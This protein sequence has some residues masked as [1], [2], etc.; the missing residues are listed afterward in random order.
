[1]CACAAFAP[2]RVAKA[3]DKQGSAHGGAVAGADSGFG[4]SGSVLFGVAVY[5]PT[6]AARP[7]NTGRALLRFAPHFDIDLIGRRLSIPIDLNFFSDRERR[8]LGKLA[9]SEFDFIAGL[10]S[11]WPV[12]DL[13][14]VEFGVRGETDRPVDRSGYTQTYGDARARLLYQLTP[15][16]PRLDAL[17]HGGGPGGVLTLG[18]FFWNPSYAARPDNTGIALLRYGANVGCDAW[19]HRL[20]LSVDATFFTDRHRNAVV[21]SELDLTLGLGLKVLSQATLQL[22]FERDMP[23]DRGGRVQQFL[24]AAAVIDL[25]SYPRHDAA[26]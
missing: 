5:N 7:D 10:T 4:I 24:I 9:P 22:A 1:M 13:A 11:S 21:P 25:G 18:W 26:N 15:A 6:Y 8:G 14:A 20:S 23:L 19:Q 2:S 16:L 3:L 17:L 12:S